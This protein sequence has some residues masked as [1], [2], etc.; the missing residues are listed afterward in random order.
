MTPAQAF[1]AALACH[2]QG[3]IA[4]A[5]ALYAAVLEQRPDDAAA[6]NNLGTALFALDR[7]PEAVARY[8][9]ALALDPAYADALVNLAKALRRLDQPLAALARLEQA[10]ALRPEDAAAENDLGN[11]LQA[12]GRHE[13]AVAR[14]ERALALQPDF[15]AAAGN[16]ANSLHALD[17]SAA[18]IAQYERAIALAPEAASHRSNLGTAL[19]ELGRLEAARRAFETAVALAPESAL[20]QLN[21][22]EV[23]RFTPGDAQL[24][25]LEAMARR[26]GAEAELYFALAKAR[27]D[28]G[29]DD[30]SFRHLLRAN[31]LK[32]AAIDYDEAA[33]LARF[34]RVRAAFTPDLIERLRGL[35]EPTELPV[36]VIG[37]PRSGTSLVEQILASHP[38]VFGAGEV[39]DLGDAVADRMVFP[40]AVPALDGAGLRAIGRAYV[41]RLG[42]RAPGAQRITDKLPSNFILAGLIPLALPGARIVHV[43][44]DP[45]DTCVSCFATLFTAGQSFAYDLAELGRYYRAY[46]ALMAHWRRVLPADA[47]LELRYEDVVADLEGAARRLIAYCGLDWDAACLSFHQTRRPV[48][49]ASAAAVRAPI[50]ARSI[51]RWQRYGETLRPLLDALEGG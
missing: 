13:E 34:E 24:A 45:R 30:G 9:R 41:A 37:M 29:D 27:A 35:G 28:L 18:A 8:E 16:L 15:A 5:A 21:L 50:H 19:R 40:E 32:R 42:A 22:A 46:D 51:G 49:T 17:R 43:R 39:M 7:L 31:A 47:M 44:R 10:L 36:F 4:E 6:H 2:R 12:L 1:E 26:G 38:A 23:K 11:V 33:T 3:R 20:C 48:R 14:Y 25:Q